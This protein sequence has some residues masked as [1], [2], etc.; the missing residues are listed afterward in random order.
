MLQIIENANYQVVFLPRDAMRKR[1]LC[2]R[3]VSVGPSVCLSDCHIGALYP[4][5]WRYR[6]ISFLAQ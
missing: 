3:P 1:G 2:S 4:V 6:Q 5:G